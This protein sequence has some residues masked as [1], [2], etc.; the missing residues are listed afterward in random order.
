MQPRGPSGPLGDPERKRQPDMRITYKQ[1]IDEGLIDRTDEEFIYSIEGDDSDYVRD[2][3]VK[4][5]CDAAGS[6]I[7][8][9]DDMMGDD[10]I[11]SRFYVDFLEPKEVNGI[12]F[13]DM[14]GITLAYDYADALKWAKELVRKKLS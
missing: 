3:A 7:E 6:T 2:T 1:M 5:A 11:Q 10:T 12:S 14:P 4:E 13:S 8:D 9:L